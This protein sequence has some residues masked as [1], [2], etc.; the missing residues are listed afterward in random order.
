MMVV[1]LVGLGV[2]LCIQTVPPYQSDPSWTFK[3]N[4][5]TAQQAVELMRLLVNNV[6]TVLLIYNP[7]LMQENF[8]NK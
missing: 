6:L 4:S 1:L 3:Q 5:K 7:L 2:L 8:D